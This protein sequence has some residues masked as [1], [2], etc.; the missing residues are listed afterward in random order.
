MPDTHPPLRLTLYRYMAFASE[1]PA[2][3]GLLVSYA[4]TDGAR[5]MIKYAMYQM[6]ELLVNPS[7]NRQL[8]NDS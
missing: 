1:H 6:L 4:K 2:R 7:V 8:S 3:Q 5:C